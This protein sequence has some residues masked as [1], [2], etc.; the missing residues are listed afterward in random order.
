MTETESEEQ[1]TVPSWA[2]WAAGVAGAA[3]LVGGLALAGDLRPTAVSGGVLLL[4]AALGLLA[5]AVGGGE[6]G[7][8]V[9]GRLDL[10]GRIATGLLGGVLGGAAHLLFA[11]A[12]GLVGLPDLLGVDLA[13]WLTPGALAGQCASGAAW[14]LAFGIAYP[15]IPGRGAVTRGL[16]FSAAPALWV[17]ID[18]YPELKY[19]LFGVELGALTFVVVGLHHMVWGLV[20]AAVVRWAERT[21]LGPA[22][23][24]LG[25]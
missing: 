17:L 11:W 21:E 15:R 1:L 20:V 4:V 8:E 14:G 13:V 23:R 9:E 3:A 2:R 24:P 6:Y 18:V 22:S 12:T 5:T 25:A 19:G 16:L 10:S 7:P